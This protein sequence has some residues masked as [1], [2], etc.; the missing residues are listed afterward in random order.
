MESVE[1]VK[2]AQYNQ[3]IYSSLVNKETVCAG[4]SKAFVCLLYELNI[5]AHVMTGY[6]ASDFHAW[7]LLSIDGAYYNMDVTWDDAVDYISRA[8]YNITDTDISA[9]HVRSEDVAGLPVC[10]ATEANWFV[11]NDLFAQSSEEFVKRAIQ[12]GIDGKGRIDIML[13]LTSQAAYDH[14]MDILQTKW[15]SAIVK[16]VAAEFSLDLYSYKFS[17]WYPSRSSLTIYIGIAP[18]S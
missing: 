9:T 10:T 7:N 8:Y 3:S 15:F 12:N 14:T 4:Y 17:R 2:D 18:V 5:P 1:Y 11:K 13:K 16:P 6:A